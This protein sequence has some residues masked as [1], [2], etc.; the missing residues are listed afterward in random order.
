MP[1]NASAASLIDPERRSINAKVRMNGT[2]HTLFQV[3]G[4][5]LGVNHKNTTAFLAELHG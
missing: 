3:V 5:W 1:A 4:T 2:N